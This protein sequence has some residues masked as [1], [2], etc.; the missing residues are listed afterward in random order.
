MFPLVLHAACLC[1]ASVAILL[2]RALPSL[3]DRAGFRWW[4]P[5]LCS[6]LVEVNKPSVAVPL[7]V[8]ACLSCVRASGLAVSPFSTSE[9][10]L[11][12]SLPSKYLQQYL[13]SRLLAVNMTL[14][15]LWSFLSAPSLRCAPAAFCSKPSAAALSAFCRA[16]PGFRLVSLSTHPRCTPC[17]PGSRV[18][19]T[20]VPPSVGT[21]GSYPRTTSNPIAAYSASPGDLMEMIF[22][23]MKSKMVFFHKNPLPWMPPLLGKGA[24]GHWALAAPGWSAVPAWGFTF[25]S[26]L[27]CHQTAGC[28]LHAWKQVPVFEI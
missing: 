17:P 8:T 28:K 14:R 24:A 21:P 12:L 23:P 13:P 27:S 20:Q 7:S 11:L 25:R 19:V 10:S 1:L 4:V 9:L 15:S 3:W 22:M 6:S 2:G 26:L 18:G 16:R 5:C